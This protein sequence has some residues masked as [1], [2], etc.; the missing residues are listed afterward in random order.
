[1]PEKKAMKDFTRVTSI[2]YP[3]SGLEKINP[4]VL[5][6]AADRGTKVHNICEA[7]VH[8]MGEFDID[9]VT[10]PY[11]ESFK[12]WWDKGHKV[13]SVEQRFFD[14]TLKITGQVDLILDTPD[15]LAI[16]DLKTSSVPSKT[17]KAQG[18]AYC[19][20]ARL[21]GLDI[22]KVYFLHLKKTGKE[23]KIYEY[24]PDP[25]FFLS[26]LRVWEHFFKKKEK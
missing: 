11:V 20:L 3:F 25:S 22:K 4:E 1:M 14:D 6:N 10:K 9:E 18:S 23:A 7:I 19:H 21:N 2:L 5:Q 13:I 12:L 15:G 8:G 26:V 24:D 17:W 16:V